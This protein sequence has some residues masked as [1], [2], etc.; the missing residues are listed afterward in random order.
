LI[1]AA[2]SILKNADFNRPYRPPLLLKIIGSVYRMVL[3]FAIIIILAFLLNYYEKYKWRAIA[4]QADSDIG[5]LGISF[6]DDDE[7]D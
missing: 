1:G 3:V 7:D 4:Q 2:K 5:A 6:D